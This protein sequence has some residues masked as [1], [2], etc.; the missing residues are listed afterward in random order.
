MPPLDSPRSPTAIGL[1]QMAKQFQA[2]AT[3]NPGVEAA[4]KYLAWQIALEKLEGCMW[5]IES[6]LVAVIAD[7]SYACDVYR[8]VCKPGAVCKLGGR[9]R[10]QML[11]IKIANRALRW[12]RTV[13]LAT[14]RNL[15]TVRIRAN[16][17]TVKIPIDSAKHAALVEVEQT[18]G[19]A[20]E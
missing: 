4:T 3:N 10:L 16:D 9:L 7:T 1:E 2:A 20:M 19:G 15:A 18:L 5:R 11:T 8:A 17:T 13:C 6:G 12:L 14:T